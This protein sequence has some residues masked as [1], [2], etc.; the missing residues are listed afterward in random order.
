MHGWERGALGARRW[1]TLLAFAGACAGNVMHA[2]AP[3]ASAPNLSDDAGVQ[4]P[5]ERSDG[6]SS[7]PMRGADDA[8]IQFDSG[9]DGSAPPAADASASSTAPKPAPM[10]LI[11]VGKPVVTSGGTGSALVNDTYFDLGFWDVSAA[12]KPWA[13]IDLG[14]GPTRIFVQVYASQGD[15]IPRSYRLETSGDS[16]NG[17]DGT[18]SARV[19]IADNTFASRAHLVDFTGQ[20]WLRVVVEQAASS[21]GRV[22]LNEIGVRDASRGSSDSWIFLGDSITA[23]TLHPGPDN[24]AG[25]VHDTFPNFYPLTINAGVGGTTT[26]D[27][28]AE[29]EA[30][31]AVYPDI[32]NW[33]VSYGTNDSASGDAAQAA[34]FGRNLQTIVE[35]LERAG[36]SVFIPR[37]PYKNGSDLT[38]YNRVIDEVVASTGAFA[39]PDLHAYF[40]AH[41]GELYDGVHPNDQGGAALNR[42]WS[43]AVAP[44][45]R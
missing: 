6:G 22:R 40:T 11:S 18:W 9:N 37:I 24:F 2:G 17:R 10:S 45:Y 25:L 35:R 23:T 4:S 19:A 43:E 29:L 5:S 27:C 8:A 34:A 16:S 30:T 33:A 7:A 1:A 13:A 15:T 42:L 44:L 36:K 26:N 32:Q 31:L 3:E 20:R 39:G 14:R 12:T 21:A 28:L 38:A 41:K